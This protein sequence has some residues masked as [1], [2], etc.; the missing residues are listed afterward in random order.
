MFLVWETR[1]FWHIQ[2]TNPLWLPKN[3]SILLQSGEKELLE[4]RLKGQKETVGETGLEKVC[5][6]N[7]MNQE[8]S[9][10]SYF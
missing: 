10:Y 9:N 8:T 3:S 6:L 1:S 2:S 4:K 7:K 5:H